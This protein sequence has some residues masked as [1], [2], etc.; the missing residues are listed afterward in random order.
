MSFFAELSRRNVI[1]VAGLYVVAAWLVVQVAD[2]MLPVFEAPG[3]VMK[4][5]VGLLAL[6]SVPAVVFSWAF[7][8]T[9]E[10]IK[11]ERDVDRS[12]STVDLTARKLDVAVIVLLVL[13]AGLVFWRPGGEPDLVARSPAPA[14]DSATQDAPGEGAEITDKS[15]AVLPFADFSQGG[16]QGWFADGLTEEILNALA[17]TPDLLVSARTSSFKYKGSDL[18]I[19]QIAAELGVAHVLEGSVRSGAGRIRVTAQL[20]RA[21]DGFHLWS[22]TYD[23]DAA[24]MIGIQEDLARQIATAMQTS[25]DPKALADMAEV[26][27]HSVEAYQ[28]YLRGVA[29]SL[30]TTQEDFRRAYEHFESARTLDLG[31]AAAHARAA[32]YW[33]NEMDPTLT[34][35]SQRDLSGSEMLARFQE[36]IDLAIRHASRDVDRLTS[37]SLKAQ[38]EQRFN[39]VIALRRELLAARPSDRISLNVILDMLTRTS[40]VDAM[41]EPLDQ[42]YARAS[43]RAEWANLYLNYGHRGPDVALAAERALPLAE[44]WRDDEFVLYQA[45]RGL[46][47]YGRID[48]ARKVLERWQQVTLRGQWS[49]IPPARQASAEGRCEEVERLLGELSPKQISERWH[50]LML[51]QRSREATELLMPYEESGNVQALSGFLSYRQFDPTPFPSLMRVLEREGVQR[52]A[53]VGVPFACPAQGGGI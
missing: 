30:P 40:E 49:L 5:L 45:H 6:G 27:T 20:I 33:L 22:Q 51:L 35:S 19:P 1:R 8:L 13:V 44:R 24:D 41:R 50:L 18:A 37:R 32:D 38:A 26:G 25:M 9:P 39:E 12:E 15:I 52:P 47:W 11:R 36:R 48:A 28:A 53:A 34:T 46:L 23:R 3:W 4:V 17:R 21:A 10:G 7:E 2:T 14:A 16:D 42:V 29:E 31:F 43:E